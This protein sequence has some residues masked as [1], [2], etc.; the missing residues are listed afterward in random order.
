MRRL[1]IGCVVLCLLPLVATAAGG[2]EPGAPPLEGVEGI[3]APELGGHLRFIASDLLEGRNTASRGERLAAE[4]LAAQ[5]RQYGAEPAGDRR[6]RSTSFFQGFP[7]EVTTPDIENT[8]LDLVVEVGGAR[9][10]LSLAPA[11][12]FHCYARGLATMEIE[13]PVVFAGR[14][15]VSEEHQID[16]YRDLEVEGRIVVV[17][18]GHPEGVPLDKRGRFRPAGFRAERL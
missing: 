10:T 6:G 3:T 18:D 8:R 11:V 15:I 12:D 7:L 14:G 16:D 2:G 17:F 5:L 4:Y 9:Q 13:A 1:S